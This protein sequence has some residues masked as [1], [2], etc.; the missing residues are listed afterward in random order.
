MYNHF[1]KGW[2]Y[3][4]SILII[5]FFLHLPFDSSDWLPITK[6]LV[7][8]AAQE[9]RIFPWD[10]V[11][12]VLGTDSVQLLIYIYNYLY[13]YCW[14]LCPQLVCIHSGLILTLTV[15]IKP[16]VY[17]IKLPIFSK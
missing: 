7:T 8:K 9:K 17:M 16:T 10:D 3:L 5:I 2:D 1:I 6:S 14:L 13:R 12:G 11:T 15:T 4:L